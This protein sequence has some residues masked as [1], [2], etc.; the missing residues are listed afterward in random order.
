MDHP[1]TN[2]SEII[3]ALEVLARALTSRDHSRFELQSKLGG[4]FSSEIVERAMAE[5]AAKG[6][7][8]PEDE[9]AARAALVWQRKLKSRGYIESQLIKRGLPVPPLDRE[10]EMQIARKAVE[11][12]FGPIEHLNDQS[13][14]Q[15]LVYLSHRGFEEHTIRTVL[16]AE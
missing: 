15:A 3:Q 2:K 12:K 7:L 11:K 9:I 4:K 10:H 14:E 1:K 8:Q 6:W 16:N 5:A 13:R